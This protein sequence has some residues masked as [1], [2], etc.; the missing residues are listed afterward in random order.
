MC[1]SCGK[2]STRGGFGKFKKGQKGKNKKLTFEEL[3]AKIERIKKE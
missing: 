1:G 3:K 2:G